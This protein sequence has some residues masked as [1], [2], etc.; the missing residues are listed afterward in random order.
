VEGII[1][2]LDSRFARVLQAATIALFILGL[3]GC[4]KGSQELP[5]VSVGEMESYKDPGYGFSLS[6]PKGWVSSTQ[7]GRAAFYSLP[8]VDQKFIDALG[9]H[10]D[11]VMIMVDV[12]TTAT[13]D[14]DRTR[15]MEEMKKNGFVLTPEQPV[16]VGGKNG[17]MF[18][19][20]GQWSKNVKESGEHIYITVD[21]LL[22]DFRFAG[23]AGLFEANSDVFKAVLASF[24][25]P[26]P[27]VPGRD[28]T[29]P[30]DAISDYNGKFFALQYP[31]NFEAESAPKGNNDEVF[32]LRGQRRDCSIRVDVF[33]AQGLTVEKVVDQNK[34]RYPRSIA[35][36]ATIAGNSAITLTYTPA[37]ETERRV[38]FTVKND[39]VY[40]ITMDWY[41]GQREEY[42]AAYDKV[43]ASVKL[44]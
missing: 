33:G 43:I 19:Y 16:T 3:I 21:T 18:M 32:A 4:D 23:F 15:T 20:T 13:P 17:T 11:G 26:K 34:S 6:Y 10:P 44:K 12:A 37:S 39:K 38:Y 8:D 5:K 30:S 31:D 41:K 1:M 2:K 42:L 36:K 28:A 29:L 25:F 27:V 22:Y 35:G 14:Q 24:Q 9:Q 40:R 7:V